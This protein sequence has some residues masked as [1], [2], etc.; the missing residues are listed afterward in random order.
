MLGYLK[1]WIAVM[2][3]DMH[4]YAEDKEWVRTAINLGQ[5]NL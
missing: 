1:Y 5:G 2:L 4:I 3:T